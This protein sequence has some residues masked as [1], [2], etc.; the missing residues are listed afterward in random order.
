[1]TR[2]V[3][4]QDLVR[5]I[6]KLARVG[7]PGKL[8][9]KEITVTSPGA[10]FWGKI[11][12]IFLTSKVLRLET[13]GGDIL[14]ITGLAKGKKLNWNFTIFGRGNIATITVKMGGVSCVYIN[15]HVV[16]DITGLGSPDD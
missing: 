7:V 16:S 10:I 4:V 6:C 2:L 11:I 14:E 9:G 13:D 3:D 5:D 15:G 1:M 12:N 8:R